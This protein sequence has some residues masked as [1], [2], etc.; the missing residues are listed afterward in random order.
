MIVGAEATDTP[1]KL[2]AELGV[3]DSVIFA[4]HAPHE[5]VPA[6][7]AMADLE[8]HLFYQDVPEKTSFGIASLEAMGAGKTVLVAANPDTYGPGLLRDDENFVLAEQGNPEALAG[9]L[10]ELLNDAPR[11]RRI[12]QAA[13]RVVRENFSWESICQR[14]LDVYRDAN[15]R[16][17]SGRRK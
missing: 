1:R 13:E 10:V 12:G 2:A 7:L 4:G 8:M 6:Y 5:D 15:D 17:K 11:C 16:V 3:K 14:T 9:R